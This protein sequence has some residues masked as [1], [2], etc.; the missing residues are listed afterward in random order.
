MGEISESP[1][2]NDA[3]KAKQLGNLFNTLF[4]PLPSKSKQLKLKVEAIESRGLQTCNSIIMMK[5]I[6]VEEEA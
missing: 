1:H 5:K 4:A 2:F 3:K 6:R